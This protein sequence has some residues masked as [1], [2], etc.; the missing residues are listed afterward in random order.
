MMERV[1]NKKLCA[2]SIDENDDGLNRDKRWA[3][4][5]LKSIKMHT[6]IIKQFKS[7]FEYIK[8]EIIA[9]EKHVY[10]DFIYQYIWMDFDVIPYTQ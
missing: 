10:D 1:E 8:S 9:Y 6:T 5:W 7:Q 3:W 2:Q 4:A